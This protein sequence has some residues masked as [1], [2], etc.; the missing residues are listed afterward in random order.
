MDTN[1]LLKEEKNCLV[2]CSRLSV[3]NIYD[4]YTIEGD[5]SEGKKIHI[6]R[7]FPVRR[8]HTL[9][10]DQQRQMTMHFPSSQYSSKKKR[11]LSL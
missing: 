7:S 2:F 1:C 3:Q 4:K 8:H 5:F 11:E 10:R 9:Y 6:R